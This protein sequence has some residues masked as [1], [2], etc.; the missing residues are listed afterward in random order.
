MKQG[1]IIIYWGPLGAMTYFYVTGDSDGRHVF[2]RLGT[3]PATA[4]ICDF[5]RISPAWMEQERQAGRLEFF[6]EGLGPEEQD[7][8]EKYNKVHEL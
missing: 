4:A 1:T 5:W 3:Y 6:P 2:A 8:I 7:R